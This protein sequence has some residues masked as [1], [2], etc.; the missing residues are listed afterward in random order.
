MSRFT[1]ALGAA[2]LSATL[3][4]AA[5][6]GS[7]KADP[8]PTTT[9]AAPTTTT[10]VTEEAW[11]ETVNA[12]CVDA[13]ERIGEIDG[14]APV[15]DQSTELSEVLGDLSAEIS[16]AGAPAGMESTVDEFVDHID[17]YVEIFAEGGSEDDLATAAGEFIVRFDDHGALLELENCNFSGGADPGSDPAD[18]GTAAWAAE[19]EAVCATITEQNMALFGQ[20]NENP[21]EHALDMQVFLGQILDGLERIEGSP[22]ADGEALL[23]AM[24]GFVDAAGELSDA[25]ATG[26]FDTY[27]AAHTAF[28]DA[29]GPVNDAAEALDAPNCGG[30]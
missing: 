15:D 18:T 29:S 2:T 9:T 3:V 24:D 10:E 25:V 20:F 21:V 28:N 26:D 30:Y 13:G 4:L 16:D 6:G 22:G 19:A 17:S 1:K 27:E 23:A 7:E 12:A 11:A 8:K 5:C 14:D